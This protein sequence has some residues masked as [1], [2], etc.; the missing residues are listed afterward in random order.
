MISGMPQMIDTLDWSDWAWP[1]RAIV[2]L[3]AAAA[4]LQLGGCA[5]RPPQSTPAARIEVTQD[6]GFTITEAADVSGELRSAYQL[7]LALLEQERFDEGIAALAALV[8]RAPG[9]SAPRVDLGIA[10]HRAGDLEGAERELQAALELNPD[11]PAALNELGIVYRKTGRF[12]DARSSYERALAIYPGLHYAR[13]NL[14]VLCDLYLND[15]GCAL[16]NYEAY[17]RTVPGDEQAS[18]WI[19]DL[20]SRAGGEG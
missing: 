13:R 12:E 2:S 17:M 8:A 9:L 7:A 10:H 6:V 15:Q 19:A 4:L 11:H 16:Q 18:I 14:A 20:R 3:L 5:G 1:R